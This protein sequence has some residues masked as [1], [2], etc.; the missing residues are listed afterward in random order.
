MFRSCDLLITLARSF[1]ADSVMKEVH[2]NSYIS[3]LFA[4]SDLGADFDEFVVEMESEERNRQ[5]PQV[6]LQ[7]AGDR[8][9]VHLT[10]L[11][12]IHSLE[13]VEGGDNAIHLGT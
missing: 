3:I 7:D 2:M 13:T 1:A 4:F 8:V 5:I 9:D 6:L 12:P 10:Q 11:V